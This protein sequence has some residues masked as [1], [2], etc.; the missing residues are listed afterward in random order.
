MEKQSDFGSVKKRS[1]SRRE[2]YEWDQ[3]CPVDWTVCTETKKKQQ[4]IIRRLSLSYKQGIVSIKDA[5]CI[6]ASVIDK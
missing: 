1:C 4:Q 3:S 6:S 5:Y 2:K